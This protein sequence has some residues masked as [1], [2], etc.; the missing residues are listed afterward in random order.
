VASATQCSDS[1]HCIF[2]RGQ[3]P[4][5]LEQQLLVVTGQGHAEA[6]RGVLQRLPGADI[7]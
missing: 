4:V 2:V 3:L 5:F 1:S 7:E 6:A